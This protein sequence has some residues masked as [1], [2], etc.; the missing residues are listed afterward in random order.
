MCFSKGRKVNRGNE[1]TLSPAGQAVHR[2]DAHGMVPTT[3]L[4]DGKPVLLGDA[5]PTDLLINLSEVQLQPWLRPL[6]HS[7]PS[8][9]GQR[10]VRTG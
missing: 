3:P 5:A 6:H 10:N 7:E 2:N 8:R 1:S 9:A 4:N